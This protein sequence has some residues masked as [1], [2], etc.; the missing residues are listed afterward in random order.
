MALTSADEKWSELFQEPY[1]KIV[2]DKPVKFSDVQVHSFTMGDVE[3]PDLY[4][5]QP[6]IEWQESEAGAW[7]MAHAED[8]PYWVR[9]PD[10]YNYGFKYYIFARLTESDQVYWQLRWGNKCS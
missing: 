8:K 1:T 7:V 10:L 6:L 9:R 3:D 2:N 5:G 4:A